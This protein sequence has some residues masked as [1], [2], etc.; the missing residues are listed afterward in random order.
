MDAPLKIFTTSF[1]IVYTTCH[2]QDMKQ[3]PLLS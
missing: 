2:L 1:S 3:T